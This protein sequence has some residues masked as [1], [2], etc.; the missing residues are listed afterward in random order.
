[1]SLRTVTSLLVV[2]SLAVAA[3]PAGPLLAEPL[4]TSRLSW[5]VNGPVYAAAA[6]GD[7][8]FIGGIFTRVA[9]RSAALGSLFAL[10]QTTGAV[11]PPLPLVDG[12]V[13]DIEPDGA[14][15]VYI[16]GRFS[17]VGGV[18]RPNLARVLADGSVDIAFAPAV[19]APVRSIARGTTALFIAGDFGLV[20][21]ATRTRLAAVDPASGATTPFTGVAFPLKIGLA[22][23]LLLA[24]GPSSL[25]ALD[26]TSGA[27]VWTA[28]IDGDTF[29][30]IVVG[31]RL[32][33]VSNSSNPAVN[34]T[35]RSVVALVP[36][37]GAVDSSWPAVVSSQQTSVLAMAVSG[38]TLYVGGSFASFG[39][40]ARTNLAAVDLTTGAVTS[41]APVTD[42]AVSAMA[43]TAGG[44]VAGG[45]FLVAGGAARE[46]LA[47]FDTAGALT[48][49]TS[50][51]YPWSVHTLRAA[52]GGRVLVGGR[53]AVNGGVARTNLAAFD[54]GGDALA[55][56]APVAAD[57]VVALEARANTVF[58]NT[59]HVAQSAGTWTLSA[60]SA[61]SGA[62]LPWA[63]TPPVTAPQLLASTDDHVYVTAS[64]GPTAGVRRADV[65]TGALDPGWL[66][67]SASSADIADGVM[68]LG[69]GTVSGG[70]TALRSVDVESGTVSPFA[71]AIGV[72]G[73]PEPPHINVLDIAVDGSTVN[74]ALMAAFSFGFGAFDAIASA[75][76]QG[77]FTAA[78]IL[79]QV[80]DGLSIAMADGQ[81]VVAKSAGGYG[82]GLSAGAPG[83]PL[84]R[85]GRPPSRSVSSAC[86]VRT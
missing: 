3:H 48:A 8:L 68:Y 67:P 31:A 24:K 6:L 54:L 9:P 60:V 76:V 42:G 16:G 19:N 4:T 41:W 57:Q 69:G 63:V 17:T 82:E 33:V 15:G 45:E 65:H 46:R 13:F 35:R 12:E 23:G 39:G 30:A 53:V 62:P 40:V 72:G 74:A 81:V 66:A 25:T 38:T 32:I 43:A 34:Q 61:D 5:V 78:G 71:P 84:W 80:G 58:V 2:V 21:G 86:S 37:T 28:P 75:S 11:V 14:G 70:T 83:Q 1:M 20:N 77:N 36:E 56:W 55:A 18:A 51:A 52:S 85:P 26:Q 22:N 10:S 64:D 49:W 44:I 47:E 59:L 7:R 79:G 73:L 29:E 50:G 27:T